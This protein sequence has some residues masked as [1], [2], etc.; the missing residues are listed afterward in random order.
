MKQY[1]YMPTYLKLVPPPTTTTTL[2]ILGPAGFAAGKKIKATIPHVS[3]AQS[4]QLTLDF[5]YG[6][7][8]LAGDED[9]GEDLDHLLPLLD[10]LL[11][12]QRSEVGVGAALVHHHDEASVA[13]GI[14]GPGCESKD[15]T[16]HWKR[17]SA[18]HG[19]FQ[20]GNTITGLGSKRQLTKIPRSCFG[21]GGKCF[22]FSFSL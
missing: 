14:T 22:M 7:P 3:L 2:T 1:C 21:G 20:S 10:P 12:G 6:H 9:G 4:F 18:S 17:G 15:K 13:L 16:R 8:L 5:L 19:L 11:R